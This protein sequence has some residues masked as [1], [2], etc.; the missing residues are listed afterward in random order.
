[1]ERGELCGV[2]WC[3]VGDCMHYLKTGT[4]H[5]QEEGRKKGAP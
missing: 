3:L 5:V 2:I 1:M 4:K